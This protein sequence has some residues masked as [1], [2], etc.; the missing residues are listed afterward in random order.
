MRSSNRGKFQILNSKSGFLDFGIWALDFGIW[1]L[2]FWFSLNLFNMNIDN[3]LVL[4]I[5]LAVIIGGIIGAEREI[6]I[7]SAGFRTLMLIC[8]GSTLFT[9][10]SQ[11]IG[12]KT[13]PDRIASNIVVGIGFIGAGVI[14]RTDNRVN[15]ITTAASIWVTAALGMA[16]G[17]GHYFVS[18]LGCFIV[19]IILVVFPFFDYYI[20]RA[21]QIRNYV[22]SFPYEVN[23][24]N[25]YEKLFKEHRLKILSHSLAKSG[26]MIKGAWTVQGK[27]KD[28][29]R[30]IDWVLKDERVNEFEF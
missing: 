27:A 11:V 25:K 14:F 10:F 26:N 30:F 3:E 15:G 16:I 20:D 29:H 28:H 21:N 19:L 2:Y 24:H 17:S 5:F 6:R 7:R 22:I 13:S 4:K 12:D 8:L 1:Y 9:V 23:E 18:I